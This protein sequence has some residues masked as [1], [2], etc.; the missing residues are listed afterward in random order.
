MIVLGRGD[1]AVYRVVVDDRVYDFSRRTDLGRRDFTINA[2]AVDLTSG[3][4]RD[5]FDGQED[6]RRRVVRMIHAR[7]FDDDPYFQ[8][9]FNAAALYAAWLDLLAQQ[10]EQQTH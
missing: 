9:L 8:P 3:E 7:N 2:I 5:E 10:Q 1:L 4:V 6:I